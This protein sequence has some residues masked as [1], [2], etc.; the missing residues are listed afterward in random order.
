MISALL[1]AGYLLPVVTDAF[2]PGDDYD[3]SGVVP[4]HLPVNMKIPLLLLS[5][6]AVLTGLFAGHIISFVSEKIIPV[7]L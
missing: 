5:A 1:T 2:F 3:Y 4:F 6:G 7:L